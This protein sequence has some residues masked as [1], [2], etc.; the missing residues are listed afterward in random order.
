MK[1]KK[2]KKRR[3]RIIPSHDVVSFLV[4]S[5]SLNYCQKSFKSSYHIG[6]LSKLWQYRF[7]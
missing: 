2:K 7:A 6:I 1:K 4:I 3:K 5:L